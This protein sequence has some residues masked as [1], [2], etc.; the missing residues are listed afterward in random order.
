M[1]WGRLDGKFPGHRKRRLGSLAADGLLARAIAQTAEQRDDGFVDA[2]WI[3]Q[4]GK[5]AER[6][7]ALHTA[8]RV[9]L[10]EEF[11][12]GTERDVTGHQ[13]PGLRPRPT[14]VHIGPHD[15]DGFLVHDFLDFNPSR[16][17]QEAKLRADRDRKRDDRGKPKLW[18]GEIAESPPPVQRTSGAPDVGLGGG[19]TESDN[20]E[21]GSGYSRAP[22]PGLVGQVM[23]VLRRCARLS[24]PD[25]C[26]VNVESAIAANPGKDPIAAAHAAVTTA[27]DPAWN[28]TW[29]PKVLAYELRKQPAP[30]HA[31]RSKAQREADDLAALQRLAEGAA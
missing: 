23:D 13:L 21:N 4:Q 29:G 3:R 26:E 20:G 5:P 31:G 14:T 25:H 28:M 11:P 24:V 2:D 19:T 8:L 27:G 16:D 30:A 12:A 17:E 9:G 1:S 15:D 18:N 10:L 6:R 7:R 22:A